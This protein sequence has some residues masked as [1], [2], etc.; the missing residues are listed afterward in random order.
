MALSIFAGMLRGKQDEKTYPIQFAALHRH[1]SESQGRMRTNQST[2]LFDTNLARPC[3]VIATNLQQTRSNA[4][5]SA[6]SA[7]VF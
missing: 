3:C 5:P 1:V 6:S 4:L 7:G 2:I